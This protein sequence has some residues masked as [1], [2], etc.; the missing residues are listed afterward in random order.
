[1]E[2]NEEQANSVFSLEEI[3]IIFW[4]KFFVKFLDEKFL[5]FFPTI[6]STNFAIVW[7]KKQKKKP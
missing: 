5:E 3:L 6:N 1:L 2:R 7:G 4:M